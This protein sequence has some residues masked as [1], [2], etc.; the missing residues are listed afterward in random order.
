MIILKTSG[1]IKFFEKLIDILIKKNKW[2][3]I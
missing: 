3:F 2:S 1:F